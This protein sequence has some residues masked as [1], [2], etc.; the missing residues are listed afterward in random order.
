MKEQNKPEIV[1]TDN[2]PFT[3]PTIDIPKGDMLIVG[4]FNGICGEFGES[5][6]FFDGKF[7]ND[8]A[9][10]IAQTINSGH[11]IVIAAS[12]ETIEYFNRVLEGFMS[13]EFFGEKLNK[14]RKLIRKSVR[15]INTTNIYNTIINNNEDNAVDVRNI[16]V[17]TSVL[18][19]I[20]KKIDTMKFDVVIQNPPYNKDLHL[21]FLEKGLDV[22]SDTG[23]MVIIEP[24]TWL[25]NV[26][27]NGKA[28]RYSAIKE[29]INGHI[30]SI[31]IENYNKEFNTGLY[32]P[33]A[34]TTIDMSKTF[35]TIDYTCCGDHKLVKSIYDCNLIGS[36]ETIWSIFNKVKSFGNMMKA[37]ITKED[38][39]REYMY[40]KYADLLPKAGCFM[41]GAVKHAGTNLDSMFANDTYYRFGYLT[42]FYDCG[43]HTIENEIQNEPLKSIQRGGAIGSHKLTDK[44]ADNIYGTQTELENWKHFIFNNKL[45]LFLNIVLTIDQHNNS[46]D[47][48][49]WLVDKQY[50][51]DE[52][53]QMFGF[54]DEEIKLI[55]STLKKY[56]R[57]SPWFKRYMCGKD[58]V[59]DEE[60]NNFIAEISK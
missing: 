28:K 16:D 50:T 10:I 33:F 26:R 40:V 19:E 36:Y 22:L 25:I 43:Y 23:K 59:S 58:S 46:K 55:D 14:Q 35:E 11:R 31:V 5:G 29:K 18:E 30:K 44:I 60:V 4:N 42:S 9:T 38:R 7:I 12:N 41:S 1:I 56:E 53:N 37:H 45:P 52:I 48:I 57:N 20:Y 2:I 34:I 54:T 17:Q 39:G 15:V 49:P 47:F 8:N 3:F 21:D 51:D 13:F 6:N 24:A 27:K 32:V